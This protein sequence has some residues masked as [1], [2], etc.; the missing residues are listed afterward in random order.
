MNL[1]EYDIKDLLLAAIKSEVESRDV[2][3]RLSSRVKNFLMKDRLQFLANEEEKHRKILFEYFCKRFDCNSFVLPSET[4]VP[5]PK[6]KIDE[7][8]SVS[9]VLLSAMEAE[10]F[11]KDFYTSLIEF[12]SD[13]AEMKTLLSYLSSMELTHYKILEIERNEAL[14]YEA[15]DFEFPMMHIGP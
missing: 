8:S 10:L 3:I 4:P 12:F 5:I 14:K 11:A 2:Y 9:D 15:Y 6:I 7:T 1:K 13:E